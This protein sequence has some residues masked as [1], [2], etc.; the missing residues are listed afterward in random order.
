MRRPAVVGL[1]LCA[2]DHTYVVEDLSGASERTRYV[3]RCVGMGGMAATAM[4]QAARLGCR[5]HL[6]TAVGAD[7]EGRLVRRRLR[8]A[9][10]DARGVVTSR[11]VP[12][13][14]AVVLCDR[15]GERRFLTPHRAPLERRVADFDL[16]PLRGAAALLVDGHFPRQ[17][18]RAALRARELGVPVVGD[19]SDPRRDYL[20]LLP[21]VDW[22]I[23]PEIFVRQWAPRTKLDAAL[24]RMR[25]RWGGAP[26]VTQGARG[27][28]YWDP[29]AG[30]VR[31]YATPRVRVRDST[32]AGD[33]FHGA[34]AAGLAHGLA[35][36]ENLARAA[37]AGAV[38][39]TAL[40]A[41]GRLAT[42]REWEGARASPSP[43]GRPRGPGRRRPS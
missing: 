5:A 24:R 32:G 21:L 35:L 10:V 11:D 29:G 14:L 13:S 9:G 22:P 37:R 1:G 31:R 38:A 12:T 3:E 34:F 41:N 17:A 16:A 40:G 6:L 23:V 25:E 36:P 42:R 19:F 39:C 33:A 43:A 18:R 20:R 30:R 4:A 2:V 26:V 7:D 15:R 8:E 27:G 28:L